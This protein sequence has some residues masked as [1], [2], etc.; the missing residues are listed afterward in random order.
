MFVN[1]LPYCPRDLQ[2]GGID[3]AGALLAIKC[4]GGWMVGGVFIRVL[5]QLSP[6]P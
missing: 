3:G 5:A 4:E 1:L 6:L 2:Q